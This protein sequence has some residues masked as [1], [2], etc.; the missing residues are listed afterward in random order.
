MEYKKTTESESG[1]H[2]LEK[3]SVTELL[4]N[5][6]KEDETVAAAVKLAIPQIKIVV[7]NIVEK[8]QAGGR[9]F[10]IGAGTSGRLGILDASE[11]EPTFGLPEG[12]I[13]GI[14]AGGRKAIT[15]PVEFAE[16]DSTQ[17]WLDLNKFSICNKDI[18]VGISAGGSTPY[19]L[20]ALQ[21]CMENKIMTVAI[22]CNANSPISKV[23]THKIEVIVGPEF[24]TGSTRMKSGTAQKMV[25]NM[26]SSSAMILQ[27]Y[28]ENNK[29]INMALTNNK[30]IDR[31]VK[32]VMEKMQLSDYETAKILLLQ[33][34]SL[35]KLF[36][37]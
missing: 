21:K 9:L 35:K 17:G 23:A 20:A 2:H 10:Y 15:T 16:D 5:I 33:N 24:I 28:I 3:M 19:V 12:I 32:I 22:S 37:R 8:M 30:L 14:I 36:K 26:I 25:L 13:T 27:G 4:Y 11:C 34:G 31:A 29:M 18:V 1:Y 6:N 7:E